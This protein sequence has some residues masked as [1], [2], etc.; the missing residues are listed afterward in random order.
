LGRVLMYLFCRL[1]VWMLLLVM[2]VVWRLLHDWMWLVLVHSWM[3]LLLIHG[4]CLADL[5]WTLMK[6]LLLRLRWLLVVHSGR[7]T[8][9][10]LPLI[11]VGR[12]RTA[13]R[14]R[15]GKVWIH[16]VRWRGRRRWWRCTSHLGWHGEVVVW[17]CDGIKHVK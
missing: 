4:R 1:L 9:K 15:H 14:K 7:R 10:H 5:R 16:S 17:R 3:L 6:R 2:H 12:T 13:R 11:I 8:L